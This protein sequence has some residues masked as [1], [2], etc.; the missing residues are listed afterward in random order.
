MVI[1]VVNGPNINMLGQREADHYGA[2]TLATLET[3]LKQIAAEK[4]L[5]QFFQSNHEGELIDYIQKIPKADRLILNAAS[6]THT[7]VGLRDALLAAQ[8]QFIE[9]HISNVYKRET[10]RH[11]S[12][13]SDIAVGIIVGLGQD[14]YMSALQYFLNQQ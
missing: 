14:S 6:L 3:N 1:H 2:F 8:T 5:L 11:H 7:S 12:H 10:F 4:V 13:L 9:V